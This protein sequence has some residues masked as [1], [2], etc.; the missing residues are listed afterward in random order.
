[1]CKGGMEVGIERSL[2]SQCNESDSCK[3]VAGHVYLSFIDGHIICPNDCLF[4]CFTFWI[5]E[6]FFFNLF[7]VV[8]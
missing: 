4:L 3:F 2:A 8:R 1:M 7:M 5:L 6:F